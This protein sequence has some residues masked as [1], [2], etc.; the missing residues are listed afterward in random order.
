MSVMPAV[1]LAETNNDLQRLQIDYYLQPELSI[2]KI[3]NSIII[4]KETIRHQLVI[5]LTRGHKT[6]KAC[7]YLE[8]CVVQVYK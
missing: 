5:N 2:I 4:S 7:M 8:I 1:I 3:I 6:I